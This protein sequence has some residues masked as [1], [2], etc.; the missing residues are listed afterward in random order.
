MALP[1]KTQPSITEFP[2]LFLVR[3]ALN[4]WLEGYSA[5]IP[6][7]IL[8]LGLI[9]DFYDQFGALRLDQLEGLEVAGFLLGSLSAPEWE[10]DERASVTVLISSFLA[11]CVPDLFEALPI[12]VWQFRCPP[13]SDREDLGRVLP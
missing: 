5:D 4:A 12:H 13:D 1:P 3:E 10:L 2:P 7:S 6:L 11:F 9:E 8:E